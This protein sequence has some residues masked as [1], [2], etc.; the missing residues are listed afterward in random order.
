MLPLLLFG[1]HR[2]EMES[3]LL[4]QKKE[5]IINL[6]VFQ[7]RSNITIQEK[8]DQ[9]YYPQMN[10]SDFIDMEVFLFNKGKYDNEL[11]NTSSWP[12]LS[13]V[14]EMLAKRRSGKISVQDSAAK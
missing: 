13:P 14:V 10:V 1:E 9:Y 5:N 11:T 7:Y 2:Q 6:L 3:L 12:V 4:Q 8:P